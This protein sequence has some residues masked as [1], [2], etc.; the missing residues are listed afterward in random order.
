MI[1]MVRGESS[2]CSNRV[3]WF[4]AQREGKVEDL[5]SLSFE[6]LDVSDATKRMDPPVIQ[7]SSVVDVGTDCPA[8][9]R[10]STGYYVAA[11]TVPA[12]A[13]IGRHEVRWTYS[14]DGV[15]TLVARVEFDVL[16]SSVPIG[17]AYALVSDLR[18][19]GVS[20]TVTTARLQMAITIA[21]RLIDAFTG[22]HFEPRWATRR[23]SGTGARALLFNDPVIAISFVGVDTDPSSTGDLTVDLDLIRVFNRHLTQGLTGGVDDDR[24]S[25]KIEFTHPDDTLGY[26]RDRYAPVGY[27][28]SSLVF[29]KGVQNI[30]V[31]GV[32]GYTEDVHSGTPWGDTPTL[33]RHATKLLALREIPT[34]KPTGVDPACREDSAIR[35]RIIEEKTREQSYKLAPI[36]KFGA[37]YTGDPEIDMLI[38]MFTRPPSIGAA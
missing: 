1:S 28:L 36:R 38:T 23:F 12:D 31:V 18:D 24:E 37:Q 21:S 7:A 14:W 35:S 4:I 19:E 34:L 32:W 9:G 27:S 29:S 8:G 30:E 10:I 13:A 16:E 5:D 26:S 33:I 3:L 20:S 11:W 2:S 22:R 17:P 25:P 6:I 15:T